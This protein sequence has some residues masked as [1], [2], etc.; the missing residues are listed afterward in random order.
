MSLKTALQV[1]LRQRYVDYI[2]RY[3]WLTVV[4]LAGVWYYAISEAPSE[5]HQGDVYRIIYVHV[6]SAFCA[7][8]AAFL[9]L[10]QSIK[11][12]VNTHHSTHVLWGKALAEIGLLC[13]FL[14][15]ITGSLW[16]RPTWGVWWTWDA[17]LTTTLILGLLYVAY[18]LLWN[19]MSSPAEKSKACGVLGI[20]IAL[21]VPIIYKS[22]TWWRTLH[23]PPSL[24]TDQNVMAPQIKT[25]LFVCIFS[26][27]AVMIFF[28]FRRFY[29]LKLEM[30]LKAQAISEFS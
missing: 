3:G 20:L 2:L 9:L 17:R 6:P 30:Q 19:A 13:T 24:F 1:S 12:L 7:F 18:L 22:V 5:K 27:L 15:L 8:F 10:V 4:V 28:S 16:G 26:L 23:Q 21:D 14:T 29:N 25:L 11:G